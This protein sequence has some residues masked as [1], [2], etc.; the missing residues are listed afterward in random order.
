MDRDGKKQ[1]RTK[2]SS[3]RLVEQLNSY[4][5]QINGDYRHPMSWGLG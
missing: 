5:R 3:L 2:L 4:H 1:A